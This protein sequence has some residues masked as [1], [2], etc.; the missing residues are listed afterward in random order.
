MQCHKFSRLDSLLEV[1]EV[2]LLP[3]VPI[4]HVA[5]LLEVGCRRESA[6]GLAHIERVPGDDAIEDTRSGHASDELVLGKGIVGRRGD[7]FLLGVEIDAEEGS[8]ST[9]IT[10]SR[11]FVKRRLLVG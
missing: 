1:G 9:D 7:D 8:Y 3:R 11:F 4:V 6:T 2:H 10:S 5:R